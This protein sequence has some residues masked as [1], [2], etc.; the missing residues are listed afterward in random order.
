MFLV[1]SF[2]TRYE[3]ND[4]PSD[5]EI[6]KKIVNTEL[7]VIANIIG[8]RGMCKSDVKIPFDNK[9]NPLM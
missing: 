7:F 9:F 6:S 2:A 1:K 8:Y 3:K 5:K 4:N